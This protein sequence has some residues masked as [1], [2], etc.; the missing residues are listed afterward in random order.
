[1][2]ESNT[3]FLD[4][5]GLQR[6]KELMDQKFGQPASESTAGMV[7]LYSSTGQNTDGA[8]TQKAVTEAID[9]SFAANDAM[10]FKG[11]LGESGTV[12]ALPDEHE[13]GWTYRVVNAGEYAGQTCEVG[14]MVICVAD[15]ESANDADWTVAQTNVDGAVTGPA[16]STDAH[17]AVFD[18]AS[19][20]V[21]KDSG[22]TIGVSVP[23]DA[24]FTDTTY[25]NATDSTAGLM[26]A[27]DKAKLDGISEGAND[28]VASLVVASSATGTAGETDVENGN[29]YLNLVD[30]GQ[31]RS[32]H[33]VVGAG[34]ATVTVDGSGV[35]TVSATAEE[36]QLYTAGQGLKLTG[37]E[38][39]NTGVLS[40]QQG[41]QNGT[42]SVNTGGSTS[43]VT[44]YTL[45]T[46]SATLGGVKTTSQ[47]QDASGYDAAP[48]IGGVVY[49]HDTTYSSIQ[50]GDIDALFEE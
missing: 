33:R 36:Q 3:K 8:M 48:I 13:V 2:A 14:D 18:G 37:S 12:T 6:F 41:E 46:A 7:K 28:Y 31:V 20:K 26:S 42:L 30:G 22:F 29:V 43:T 16:S 44:A 4:L 23:A 45:P 32:S 47:V 5:A 10:V 50:N 35:I 19:G 9:A 40:V 34:Q 27:E 24:K 21:I 38:F 11:T 49:Y 17:V 25:S 15:G 39:S 1:M